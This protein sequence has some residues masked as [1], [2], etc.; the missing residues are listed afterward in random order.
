MAS[1]SL[2]RKPLSLLEKK[3]EGGQRTSGEES[4]I[5]LSSFPLKF[6]GGK[7]KKSPQSKNS[8]EPKNFGDE[9][10]S[11]PAEATERP[12]PRSLGY[13]GGAP[14]PRAPLRRRG[15]RGGPGGAAGAAAGARVQS[16]RT[17][18]G[19]GRGRR[20]SPGRAL[21]GGGGG[22]GEAVGVGEEVKTRAGLLSIRKRQSVP[23][24]GL[25]ALELLLGEEREEKKGR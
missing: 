21:G 3:K 14:E 10:Q 9:G 16:R 13:P 6:P 1:R 5:R 22:R 25:S 18:A 11:S 4:A 24:R 12:E 20:Q 23:G 17:A 15:G 2:S 8:N 7:K 19:L